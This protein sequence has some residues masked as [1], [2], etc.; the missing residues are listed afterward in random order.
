MGLEAL[1][2]YAAGPITG[3]GLNSF[4]DVLFSTLWFLWAFALLQL[5]ALPF[6]VAVRELVVAAGVGGAA[7]DAPPPALR[8]GALGGALAA[9][10]LAIVVVDVAAALAFD[11]SAGGRVVW[12]RACPPPRSARSSSAPRTPHGR[13]R[14]PRRRRGAHRTR[15]PSAAPPSCP[16]SP[17]RCCRRRPSAPV[18]DCGMYDFLS[19]NL[20]HALLLLLAC[21][22]GGFAAQEASAAARRLLG[23]APAGALCVG[24]LLFS[25]YWPYF[26]AWQPAYVRRNAMLMT[27]QSDL[28]P[29]C[30]T[31]A[32]VMATPRAQRWAVWDAGS[33]SCHCQREPCDELAPCCLN[34]SPTTPA[35][36]PTARRR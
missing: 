16:S 19:L 24:A 28:P 33:A 35:A 34:A 4:F 10:A 15:S 14:A 36:A 32:T 12:P 18:P 2:R 21:L 5:V 1:S 13:R 22:H 6:W 23:G 27:Y 9:H 29:S 8:R 26:T 11:L 7:D 3:R 31:N 30:P 17:S 20:A 25:M